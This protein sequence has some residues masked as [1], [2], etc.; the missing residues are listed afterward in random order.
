M[1][2]PTMNLSS[3]PMRLTPPPASPS[4]ATSP[5]QQTEP[6]TTDSQ[7]NPPW[8]PAKTITGQRLGA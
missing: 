6:R 7:A 5:S 4:C 3:S 1:D 8:N 2:W